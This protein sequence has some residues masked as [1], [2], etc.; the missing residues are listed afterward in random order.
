MAVNRDNLK[1]QNADRIGK[2]SNRHKTQKK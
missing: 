1:K 2:L